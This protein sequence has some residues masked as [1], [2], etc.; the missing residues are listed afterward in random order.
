VQGQAGVKTLEPGS[1]FSSKVESVHRVSSE[2][3]EKS[4]IYVGTDGKFD[5]IS[6][7]P[8]K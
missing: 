1:Y 8:K 4:I 2:A 7:Q 3:G 5:V 6:K